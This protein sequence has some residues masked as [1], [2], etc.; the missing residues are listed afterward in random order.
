MIIAKT[1][2]EVREQIW[3]W[4]S[5]G[6]TIGLCPTMGYLHEG[7]LSLMEASKKD[8]DYTVATIFVNPM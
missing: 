8:N 2:N 4:K 6:K 1:I 3:Q 5:E 7:H